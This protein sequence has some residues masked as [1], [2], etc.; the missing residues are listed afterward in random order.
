MCFANEQGLQVTYLVFGRQGA[1]PGLCYAQAKL[2]RCSEREHVVSE[3]DTQV[4]ESTALGGG[5]LQSG[6]D[7]NPPPSLLLWYLRPQLHRDSHSCGAEG[8]GKR[9]RTMDSYCCANLAGYSAVSRDLKLP[10]KQVAR[11]RFF[12]EIGAVSAHGYHDDIC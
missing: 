2:R 8:A 9:P 3:G 5:V 10:V 7:A 6:S 11:A 4:L 12:S 1:I